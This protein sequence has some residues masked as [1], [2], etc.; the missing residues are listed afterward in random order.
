[1]V[2][3]FHMM[4]DQLS[5]GTNVLIT[6]MFD[7]MLVWKYLK[8]QLTNRRVQRLSEQALIEGMA[9]SNLHQ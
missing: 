8:N 2:F 6:V 3:Y 4:Q 5:D 1:M 7:L 9:A